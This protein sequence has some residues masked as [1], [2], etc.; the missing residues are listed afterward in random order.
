M[1][2]GSPG[3]QASLAGP[4]I[5]E[6]LLAGGLI[7][8]PFFEGASRFRETP[9]LVDARAYEGMCRAAEALVRVHD[10]AARVLAADDALVDEFFELTPCQKLLWLESA[11]FWH[12]YARA[13]VFDTP[14][15]YLA[16]ELNSDTPTGQAE[17]LALAAIACESEA[18][19][20]A[21]GE[22]W[23][24]NAGLADAMADMF[25]AYASA[26]LGA[27]FERTA[28]IVY[29]T[30]LTE[31]LPLI[32][33]LEGWLA[34]R[35]FRV[36][37]GAPHNLETAAD[38]RASLFGTACSLVVRHYKTDWWT[39]R[40]PVWLG[41][42]PFD[43]PLPLAGPLELLAR[44]ELDGRSVVVN[45]FGAVLTQNKRMLALLWEHMDLLS[46]EGQQTVRAHVPETLRLESLH[47][48]MLS[49]ERESWVLKSDYGCE[50]DE[51]VVGHEL[52][53]A[54]WDRALAQALPGRWVAQ[55]RFS[56]RQ[57]GAG[58]EVVNHG[59]YVVAGQAVGLYAR[60]HAGATD[61][62]AKSAGALIQRGSR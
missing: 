10:E 62:H 38:G 61:R 8:D 29:P 50:G 58:G 55:R 12:G 57:S 48:A 7:G 43:D 15:G 19:R 53:Q 4:S 39:E 49:V 41:D 54:A 20:I 42:P 30:D 1:S 28:G 21:T 11:P 13:D 9:V 60:T 25:E 52:T 37:T 6:R 32:R 31:D 24:P 56:P 26:R 47:P 33:L 35:G 5:A 23:D 18:A 45:P 3:A 17:A 44:A 59:V 16:C 2:V 46:S 51:V 27:R 22:L 36:V 40:V 34:G 14:A